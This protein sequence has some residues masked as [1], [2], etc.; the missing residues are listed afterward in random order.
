M[1]WGVL[2]DDGA[3]HH[4]LALEARQQHR[5]I[6]HA[7]IRF[8]REHL[9]DG[10]PPRRTFANLHFDSFGLIEPLGF[11]GIKAGELELMIPL[12]LKHDRR[13]GAGRRQGQQHRRHHQTKSAPCLRGKQTENKG[14]EAGDRGHAKA[15]WPGSY[16]AEDV[17]KRR[18]T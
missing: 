14:L 9:V 10:G 17:L 4:G 8:S 18:T 1:N 5:F 3:G 12:E 7:E 11:G 15:E 2:E 13:F 16:L 6:R